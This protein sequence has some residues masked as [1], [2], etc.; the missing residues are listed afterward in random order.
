MSHKIIGLINEEFYC[1]YKNVRGL[2]V[3]GMED[4]KKLFRYVRPYL[5]S[6]VAGLSCL[7]VV[8]LA[9]LAFPWLLKFLIDDVL[10]TG[11][12]VILNYIALAA[13]LLY[14][15]KGIFNYA[16]VYLLSGLGQRVI[17][18]I[19]NDIYKHLQSLS[20]SYFERQRTGDLM[21]RAT[22]DVNIIQRSLTT[23]ISSLVLQPLMIF[24]II[25]FLIYIN[26]K[27][28]LVAFVIAPLVAYA[29]NKF[30]RKM[31]TV[32]T[33]IQDRL[34]IVT[35]ILQ[36]TLSGIRIVKA[37]N[38]EDLEINKFTEANEETLAANMKGVQI[39]ATLTPVVEL[40]IALGA[41][42]FLWYGGRQVLAEKMTTG[43]LI[44][45][46]GYIGLLISPI[47]V[48]SNN[49]NLFQRAVG[50]SERIFDLLSVEEKVEE[51][52][53]AREMPQIEGEVEFKDVSFSYTSSEKVLKNI[54]LKASPGE[55]I[56][57]VGHS[58]AG[59]S[60]LANLIPR[61]Y[62]I[63]RGQ[64]LIDNIDIRGV[65]LESLR[66]QIGIVPQETILFQGTIAENIAYGSRDQDKEK[67]KEAARKANAH[68]FINQFEHGYETM[69]GERGAS[70]SG[71][72]KQ[73]IS[74]ARAILIN[75]RIL[76]LDEATSSLDTRSETLVQEALERLMAA[77]TT[78]IIAHRLST[79]I[80]ADKII[81][82]ENGE[83]VE[84]G[85]HRELMDKKRNYFNLYQS[86]LQNSGEDNNE[87]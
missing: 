63:N 27:L 51:A 1:K 24:G 2:A 72:Q 41:A 38:T 62:D 33:R 52:E 39:R 85:T 43:E 66:N 35:T 16:Q 48:L 56:G 28:A 81:V 40:I 74:I 21:S 70:L 34:S 26:W 23:G 4:Y 15:I 12:A 42:G 13:V 83:I 87:G 73:R 54:N 86:Q 14:F 6:L 19:R 79:I 25:V 49:Y 17:V 69:V 3:A 29:I 11:N 53:D 57:L 59:K 37:F 9:D 32:S 80:G 47:N 76:I 18:D 68:D 71:G 30:G 55:T 77:R 64:I 10:I 45:F 46:L 82:I 31:R 5:W 44:T 50:A 75:P 78:F 67:I 61:F 65:T 84:R 60:S 36:E 58:G 20:L 7:V 8:G 22:N